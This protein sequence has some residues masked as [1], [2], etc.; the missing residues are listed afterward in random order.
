MLPSSHHCSLP[1]PSPPLPPACLCT[2]WLHSLNHPPP[3]IQHTQCNTFSVNMR[4]ESTVLLRALWDAVPGF[5]PVYFEFLG[6]F[7]DFARKFKRWGMR[8]W[9]R[10]ESAH[11]SSHMHTR[12]LY[13]QCAAA[14]C[15]VFWMQFARL[16]RDAEGGQHALLSC[17]PPDSCC[18]CILSLLPTSKRVAAPH[19]HPPPPDAHAGRHRSVRCGRA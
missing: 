19:K 12:L 9:T 17:T 1:L 18:R 4:R 15:F 6:S 5:R 10:N 11:A 14:L 13:S 3:A 2:C 8:A 16:P 7:E